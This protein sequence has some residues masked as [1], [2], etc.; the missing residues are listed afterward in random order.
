MNEPLHDEWLS[1]YLDDELSAEERARVEQWLTDDPAARRR[2]D[3]LRAVGAS[4]KSLPAYRLDEDLSDRVLRAAERRILAEPTA[5]TDVPRPAEPLAPRGIARRL[6]NPRGLAWAGLAAAVALLLYVMPFEPSDENHNLA[7]LPDEAV[8]EKAAT[9]PAAPDKDADKKSSSE[10]SSEPAFKAAPSSSADGRP[11]APESDAARQ[12]LNNVTEPKV[13]L[14][15]PSSHGRAMSKMAAA[16]KPAETPAKRYLGKAAPPQKTGQPTFLDYGK[17]RSDVAAGTPVQRALTNQANLLVVNCTLS[18]E[19]IQNR[20]FTQAL[21]MN[22]IDVVSIPSGQRRLAEQVAVQNARLVPG[23]GRQSLRVEETRGR[24]LAT[25]EK[26]EGEDDAFAP[27]RT[28]GETK[29]SEEKLGESLESN[30][31]K[32]SPDS[33]PAL[34]E[35][36]AGNEAEVILVEGDPE[37]IAATLSS[38]ARRK[39]MTLSIAPQQ[40]GLR[41]SIQGNIAGPG[42]A[43]DAINKETLNRWL[44]ERNLAQTPSGLIENAPTGQQTDGEELNQQPG[45]DGRQIARQRGE[46]RSELPRGTAQR[47]ARVALDE[48]P[49]PAAMPSATAPSSLGYSPA[50]NQWAAPPAAVQQAPV[51][52]EA[53]QDWLDATR[54]QRQLSRLQ[55]LF[56]LQTAPTEQPPGA[57]EAAQPKADQPPAAPAKQPTP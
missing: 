24:G 30:L 14:K 34:N 31:L 53:T 7:L 21:G 41:Q 5:P 43:G 36:I 20:A 17:S 10:V 33:R 37:Q 22:R 25:E 27:R 51:Q 28:A 4:L 18:P 49:A 19:A 48:P 16:P 32:P 40:A 11:V 3:E 1:A 12:T 44:K 56:V 2:L 6:L 9:A 29:S 50:T 45:E 47:L 57:A 23:A 26:V 13:A 54:D 38:L 8:S 39:D 46:S 42:N 35:Q 52:R 15:T 55:V